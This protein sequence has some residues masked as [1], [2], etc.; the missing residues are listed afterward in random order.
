MPA[1]LA[2]AAGVMALLATG[3]G[4]AAAQ[5]K[6][7]SWLVRVRAVDIK[8]EDKSDPIPAL[9]VPT[10]A[11]HVSDKWIPEVDITYFLTRNLAAEL[12]LTYPQKHNVTVTQSAIGGFQAGT[13]KHLPPTLTLQWH[14]L[15]EGQFR[16]YAGIGINYTRISSVNLRVPAPVNLPLNLENSS[17]GLAVGAG[18]DVKLN[19][20]L[21]LNVDLKKV[22][23]RSDVSAGGV[24][25]SSVKLDPWLF[26]IGLGWRF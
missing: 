16:P 15:P 24:K 5:T 11:I 4:V 14:F 8:T 10:D 1:K 17:V 21:F 18:F 25:V 26:G 6:E 9:G 19:D 22:Q 12:V 13:F 7:G 23:I 20:Q 2:I 3:V